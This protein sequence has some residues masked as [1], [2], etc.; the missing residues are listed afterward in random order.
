M[1]AALSALDFGM[2]LVPSCLCRKALTKEVNF[3][4]WD[5][6]ASEISSWTCFWCAQALLRTNA[7]VPLKSRAEEATG[8]HLREHPDSQAS[9]LQRKRPHFPLKTPERE[10]W[11]QK[12]KKRVEAP[13]PQGATPRAHRASP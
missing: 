2:L 3:L 10:A 13:R 9:S 4:P 5:D 8:N 1:R 6:I 12:T 7:A 11:L